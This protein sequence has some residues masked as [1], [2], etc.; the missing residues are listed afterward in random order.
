[1]LAVLLTL[2]LAVYASEAAGE[3]GGYSGPAEVSAV[4]DL[5]G[6][7][8]SP[9]PECPPGCVC[10]CACACWGSAAIVPKIGST[11]AQIVVA[12]PIDSPT[13]RRPVRLEPEPR[14]RPPLV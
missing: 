14:L 1:M 11:E 12:S 5:P 6:A 4:S 9:A 3:A 13:E 8:S 2:G 10:P 7:P